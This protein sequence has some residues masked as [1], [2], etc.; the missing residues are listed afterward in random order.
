MATVT[1]T[2]APVKNVTND[3]AVRAAIKRAK[4]L[5]AIEQA[6]E[7]AKRERKALE[8]STIFPAFAEAGA[9]ELIILG[10]TA[11]KLSSV[12]TTNLYDYK[13]LLNVFPEAHKAIH[14]VSHYRFI[15]Y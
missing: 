12:R 7:A 3:K 11:A 15:T 4:E 2:P 14:S 8:E 13:T 1:L 6:G 10:Q 9:E 5:K